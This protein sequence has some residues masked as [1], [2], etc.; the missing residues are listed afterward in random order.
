MTTT[1]SD[2]LD[3]MTHTVLASDLLEGIPRGGARGLLN[4]ARGG[5]SSR[6]I[7]FSKRDFIRKV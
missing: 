2:L 4:H 7:A 5:L 3:S 1:Q 6:N